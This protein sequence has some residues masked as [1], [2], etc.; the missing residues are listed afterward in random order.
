M[1]KNEDIYNNI[2]D[3]EF[4]KKLIANP[5]KYAK[6]LGY[7]IKDD[8]QIKVVKNTKNIMYINLVEVDGSKELDLTQVQ[9]AGTST[10]GTAGT[11]GTLGSISTTFLCSSTAST[12][13]TAA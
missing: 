6:E 3:K 4:R 1:I 8:T 7:D 9:A 11:A 10:A 12:A 13:G 2:I 5:S